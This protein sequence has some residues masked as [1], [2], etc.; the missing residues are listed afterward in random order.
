M[1]EYENPTK[2]DN[3]RVRESGESEWEFNFDERMLRI[4]FG[5]LAFVSA[6]MDPRCCV[7]FEKDKI[8]VCMIKETLGNCEREAA[9][10]NTLLKVVP[11][12]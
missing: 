7:R 4:Y 9:K 3:A 6:I 2:R 5:L 12:S 1:A 10:Q 11:L 8:G